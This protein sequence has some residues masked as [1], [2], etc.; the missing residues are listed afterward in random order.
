MA[1]NI[2]GDA[3]GTQ[4]Q[5]TKQPAST[6][7]KQLIGVQSSAQFFNGIGGRGRRLAQALGLLG[8]AVME[9]GVNSIERQKMIAQRAEQI[10]EAATPEDFETRST[11]SMLSESDVAGQL[12]DNPWAVALVDK[13]RGRNHNAEMNLAYNDL[14]Q[15]EGRKDSWIDEASRYREFA[16]KWYKEHVDTAL[17]KVGYQEGFYQ[18]MQTDTLN[19]A[20][21]SQ[22]KRNN[23]MTWQRDSNFLASLDDVFVN[24]NDRPE[25]ESLKML[26]TIYG[27]Y[28]TAN[29]TPDKIQEA[30]DKFV[31]NMAESG[32]LT[33]AVKKAIG[34]ED[35]MTGN[36]G[37]R[38]TIKD[39]L[40]LDMYDMLSTRGKRNALQQKQID[41]ENNINSCKTV[42]ELQSLYQKMP[43]QEQRAWQPIFNK[44][45]T[46]IQDEKKKALIAKANE[47]DVAFTTT[48]MGAAFDGVCQNILDGTSINVPTS[49][50]DVKYMA[51]DG[52]MKAL[53]YT[54]ASVLIQQYIQT[55]IINNDN[56][57]MRDKAVQ[58]LRLL[59][60][61]VFDK[62]SKSWDA[63]MLDAFERVD[64]NDSGSPLY[65]T[66]MQAV[67]MM[68]F[69]P[70]QAQRIM[71]SK[72]YGMASA[73]TMLTD[74][75]GPEKAMELFT[76]AR[77]MDEDTRTE[78]KKE[79]TDDLKTASL[80]LHSLGTLDETQALY[81][82]DP[83]MSG[84]LSTTMLYLRGSGISR[85]KAL[86]LI[87][88]QFDKTYAEYEG[89]FVP[90]TLFDN[91]ASDKEGVGI[92]YMDA[93]KK[94]YVDAQL[95]TGR[96]V[97]E[98]S[99][100]WKWKPS[101]GE[102][103]LIDYDNP[104]VPAK[105]YTVDEFIDATNT[106]AEEA[107]AKQS[108]ESKAQ[109]QRNAKYEE[110]KQKA[111][112]TVQALLEKNG[113]GNTTYGDL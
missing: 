91:Y 105:R 2:V 48:N 64:P 16:D 17:N 68:H 27:E 3:V 76:S 95:Q 8:D 60:H 74:M 29:G 69:A 101:V 93:M 39:I 52:S 14:V 34:D 56:L 94:Q 55:H 82:D 19:Q 75:W 81:M 40:N 47:Q 63:T 43:V 49:L 113:F 28:K 10:A 79:S 107:Y 59:S 83:E 36:D 70:M 61:P 89:G 80:P 66:C 112:S 110:L 65:N 99:L 42:T 30:T 84:M 85:E 32:L 24:W 5:F 111:K 54:D 108:E 22:T 58:T 38:I 51:A 31:Q 7:Q 44:R 86:E 35:I 104:G 71:G 46:E 97:D 92:Q 102:F 9:Y 15:K 41:T 18:N 13:A 77:T 90:R 25:E 1:N 50:S 106:W 11:I 72:T 109:E 6:Y 100:Q 21:A 62:V 4:R 73:L 33:D 23:E 12:V 37:S 26:H 57:S 67:E 88:T 78:Y 98:D 53:A 103:W 87:Q 96:L 45:Y 20:S